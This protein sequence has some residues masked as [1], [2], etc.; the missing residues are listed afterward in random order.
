MMFEIYSTPIE[1]SVPAGSR[2]PQCELYYLAR[3]QHKLN[4]PFIENDYQK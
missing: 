2:I 3:I 1:I 4:N